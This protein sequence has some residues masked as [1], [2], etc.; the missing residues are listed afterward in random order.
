MTAPLRVI[1]V[2]SPF[3]DDRF[4]WVAAAL[5][6]TQLPACASRVPVEVHVLD[7]PVARL[8]NALEG[9]SGVV[10]LDAVHS[11]AF[12]GTLHRIDAADLDT[13]ASPVSS[14]DLG[15]VA[16]LQLARTLGTLPAHMTIFGLEADLAHE[17]EDLSAA[18]HANLEQVTREVYQLVRTWQTNMER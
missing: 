7:R 5:L 15:V 14:H 9:A 1:G 4:G 8:I 13:D 16:A 6:K 17:G 18:M 11:G 12:P 2:G 3:G 10:L